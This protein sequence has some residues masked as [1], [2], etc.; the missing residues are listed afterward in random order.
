MRQPK[1][2]G[3]QQQDTPF[4]H[5]KSCEGRDSNPEHTR[6]KGRCSFHNRVPLALQLHL[7]CINGPDPRGLW[8]P[9]WLCV[10]RGG[11]RR[12]EAARGDGRAIRCGMVPDQSFSENS[13]RSHCLLRIEASRKMAFHGVLVFE[14]NRHG[15]P[16]HDSRRRG[17]SG[18]SS[19]TAQPGSPL[20]PG[21][22][23]SGPSACS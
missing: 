17:R 23:R 2:R 21:R 14:N 20:Q 1:N 8:Y 7:D 19:S 3:S 6:K 18:S 16:S 12:R 22:G 11:T 4:R 9:R 15:H 5:R 13:W 10:D